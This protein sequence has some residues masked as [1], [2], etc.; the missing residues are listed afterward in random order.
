MPPV[1]S[2]R[3]T[4]ATTRNVCERGERLELRNNGQPR[5]LAD[6]RPSRAVSRNRSIGTAGVSGFRPDPFDHQEEF[7]RAVD[8][9]RYAVRPI[10]PHELSLGDV[11]QTIN[12]LG[13]AVLHQERRVRPS[14][15]PRELDQLAQAR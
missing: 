12:S 7:I 13:V 15:R 10:G 14:I 9:A 6:T 2:A 1:E 3:R 5:R 4:S 11:V 8:G